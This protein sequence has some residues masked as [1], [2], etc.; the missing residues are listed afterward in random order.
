MK[1]TKSIA[2]TPTSSNLSGSDNQSTKD[3]LNANMPTA[4]TSDSQA[5]T[6][7]AP[8]Y[9]IKTIP[10]PEFNPKKKLPKGYVSPFACLDG[11]SVLKNRM[12]L[13]KNRWPMAHF[14]PSSYESLRDS[15]RCSKHVGDYVMCGD[16]AVMK[17]GLMAPLGRLVIPETEKEYQ[18]RIYR[19]Q[20][21]AEKEAILDALEQNLKSD[22]YEMLREKSGMDVK[23]A[24]AV[25]VDRT[26]HVVKST[27]SGSI[28][29]KSSS[30]SEFDDPDQM[31]L[32]F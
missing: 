25:S 11:R 10:V 23:L 17:R 12:Y 27:V 9:T 16:Y 29:I 1:A 7:A 30:A 26:K 4:M 31:E 14:A 22:V 3:Q 2:K 13:L 28:P 21:Q 5:N 8:K 6:E 15:I 32:D 24:F 20:L 18:E 19:E